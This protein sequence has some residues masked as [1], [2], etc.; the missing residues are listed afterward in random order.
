MIPLSEFEPHRACELAEQAARSSARSPSR[1]R[2]RLLEFTEIRLRVH[3]RYP[4]VN[5]M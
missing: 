4:L 1:H 5:Y 3:G 2:P